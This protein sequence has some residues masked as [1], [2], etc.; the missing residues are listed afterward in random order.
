MVPFRLVVQPG[1]PIA[2]QVAFA[3]KKAIFSGKLRP[4][5][6]FPSVRALGR[7]MK[8]HANTAQKVISQLAAEG[9]IEVLP[10]IGTLVAQPAAPRSGRS[11]LL[12]GDV[13]QLT[14]QAMQI[15]M[16]LEEL[17][18]AVGECWHRLAGKDGR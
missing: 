1:V 18:S 13:E 6:A 11:R 17:Q 12:A 15:G 10:G 8:I 3:A 4:G 9:L 5:D 7:A 16:S 2:D 14:V